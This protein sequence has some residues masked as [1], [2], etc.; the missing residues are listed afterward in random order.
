MGSSALPV[1]GWAY[2][3]LADYARV[4]LHAL[5]CDEIACRRSLRLIESCFAIALSRDEGEGE[6]E[7]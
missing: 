5:A 7:G 2:V 1:R 6:G 4:L 3:A